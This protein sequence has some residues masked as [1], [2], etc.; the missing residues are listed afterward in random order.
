MLDLND[1][2][3]RLFANIN[4][5]PTEHW[6]HTLTGPQVTVSCAQCQMV[7]PCPTRTALREHTG[8]KEP[9]APAPE[10]LNAL[11]DP[12]AYGW[13]DQTN[14]GVA[15]GV[16]LT[17]GGEITVDTPGAVVEN[18]VLDGVTVRA[19]DV[20]IRDCVI[21]RAPTP[22]YGCVRLQ[23]GAD[24]LHLERCELYYTEPSD[25]CAIVGGSSG[26]YTLSRC[27]IHSFTEGPRLNPKSA[28]IGCYI[29][30]P[31][32]FPGGHID[33]LQATRGE[34]L[35]IADNTLV[36]SNPDGNQFNAAIL[37]KTDDGPISRVEIRGNLM[38]GGNYTLSLSEAHHPIGDIIVRDNR[39]GSDHQY[40]PVV[41]RHVNNLHWNNNVYDHDNSPILP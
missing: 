37:L 31:V 35:L 15:E 39:F 30:S 4:H 7:W 22:G 17:E 16:N 12:S 6:S 5:R 33:V 19:P 21:R 36:A 28:V 14:T 34:D 25:G 26:A 40:G 1:S 20:T 29:H 9:P 3:V 13:P 11:A 8:P 41:A 18:M 2:D 27:H 10:L 24:N 23:T 38:T 32:P